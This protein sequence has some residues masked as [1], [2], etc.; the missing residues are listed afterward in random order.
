MVRIVL[1]MMMSALLAGCAALDLK[2]G[3]DDDALTKIKKVGV[4]SV[5]GTTFRGVYIGTTVFNNTAFSG[6]VADWQVDKT[7]EEKT[8]AQLRANQQAVSS[9]K[10][11]TPS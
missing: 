9:P 3:L 5:L 10:C 11:N 7:A 1:A 2:R 6:S 8:L 4:V